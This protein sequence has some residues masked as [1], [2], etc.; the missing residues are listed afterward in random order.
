MTYS[1]SEIAE[2][3]GVAPSTIR[4]YDKKGMLPFLARSNGGIRRFTETD[5]EWLKIIECLKK[6]GMSLS[7]IKQYIHMALEGDSTLEARYELIKKQRSAIENQLREL[8]EMRDTLDYK[9]WYY[10]TSVAAGTNSIHDGD[11]IEDIPDELKA[12]YL[13]L[14]SPEK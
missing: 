11:T 13:K 12:I 9:C 14:K 4:F 10:E 2:L 3:I 8:Y 7:D 1:I 5:Y 6:T